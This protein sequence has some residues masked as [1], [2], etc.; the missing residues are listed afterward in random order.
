MLPCGY[1]WQKEVENVNADSLSVVLHGFAFLSQDFLLRSSFSS[2]A[3][4]QL[5]EHFDNF[6]QFCGRQKIRTQNKNQNSILRQTENHLNTAFCK[7]MSAIWWSG[8]L[9]GSFVTGIPWPFT[10]WLIQNARENFL[11]VVS[12]FNYKNLC[13]SDLLSWCHFETC[14]QIGDFW[15]LWQIS[16][17]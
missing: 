12:G 17:N 1:Q 8:F 6:S 2:R 5:H 4:Q 9:L 10:N 16:W 3:F 11:W 14:S 7:V 15:R 13:L